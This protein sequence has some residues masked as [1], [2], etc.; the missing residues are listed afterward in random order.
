VNKDSQL[1]IGEP[2]HF[3]GDAISTEPFRHQTATAKKSLHQ[4]HQ[5]HQK[6]HRMPYSFHILQAI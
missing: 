4:P 5:T 2:L 6:N 1:G 3:W